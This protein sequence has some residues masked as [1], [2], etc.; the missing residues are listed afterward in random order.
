[1]DQ[2]REIVRR[3]ARESIRLDPLLAEA[4]DATGWV[5]AMDLEWTEAEKSFR[6]AL[7]LNPSLTSTY[8]DFVFSTL[9]PKAKPSPS[10][11]HDLRRPRRPGARVSGY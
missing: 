10:A 6:R 9:L 8:T 7:E 3:D 2:A 4:H 11:G 5:H 1:V